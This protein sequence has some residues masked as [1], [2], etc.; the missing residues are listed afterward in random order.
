ML[1]RIAALPQTEETWLGGRR[2]LP[3]TARD[4]MPVMLVSWA[5]MTTDQLV[6]SGLIPQTDNPEPI[7]FS[8]C[9]AMLEPES[10]AHE[11]RRPRELI[12]DEEELAELIG[13]QLEPL[14]IEVA[15]GGGDLLDELI[16][17]VSADLTKA[18][19]TSLLDEP[20]IKPADI[21]AFY[22][23]GREF[24]AIAPWKVAEADQVMG[25]EF[26][27]TPDAAPLCVSINDDSEGLTIYQNVED[28]DLASEME[29]EE[30]WADLLPG[31]PPLEV[32]VLT[33]HYQHA[34]DMNED[35]L[36]RVSASNC[37]LLGPGWYPEL[38]A[39]APEEGARKVTTDDVRVATAVMTAVAKLMQQH[40]GLFIEEEV[41][42]VTVE[43]TVPGLESLGTVKITAPH[44]DVLAAMSEEDD[45]DDD[46]DEMMMGD[47]DD[48]DGDFGDDDDD[49]DAGSDDGDDGDD[50]SDDDG[51]A[52][53]PVLG[54]YGFSEGN[55]DGDTDA[56]DDQN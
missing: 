4:T 35:R 5:S 42:A 52:P 1:E 37:E 7:L 47:D 16:D 46:D 31:I 28:W 21:A 55:G 49:D 23:A 13:D 32:P 24:A 45:D 18:L 6:G 36:A 40:G 19:D 34:V 17:S 44:P 22:R 11:A 38:E 14:G 25:V 33:L 41:E 30:D 20:D 12:I 43:L 29:D 8:L 15:V 48:E 56:D 9:R 53:D 26:S 10:G 27:S 51:G 3:P 54:E 2:P 39:L 50:A